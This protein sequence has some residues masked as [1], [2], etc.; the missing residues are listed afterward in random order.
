MVAGLYSTEAL[1]WAQAMLLNSPR[2]RARMRPAVDRPWSFSSELKPGSS[3]VVGPLNCDPARRA[4]TLR[5]TWILLAT[6]S[7][8]QGFAMLPNRRVVLW[9]L[10]L[11]LVLSRRIL[12]EEPPVIPIGLDAYRQWER[13]QY[14]R[15]GARAYMRSTYDRG[16]GNEGA[17]ASHFLYQ[18]AGDFNVALDVEGPGLPYFARYNH[19]HGSPWHYEV[20]G[21]DHLVQESSTAAPNRPVKDSV[22]LPQELFPRPLAWTWSD[23]QGA[24]LSWIPVPFQHSFRI[25]TRAPI[26]AR[27][28]ISTTSMFRGPASLALC[29]R[30]TARRLPTPTC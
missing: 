25:A 11:L 29:T 23:T 21:T 13:W 28:T 15:I 27:A 16:G 20:D 12:A 3:G 19:W 22:F 30:G 5:L 9:T 6:N 26:T 2:S 8:N 4:T 17:D 1:S 10:G 24:D 18:E 14:Q 7:R